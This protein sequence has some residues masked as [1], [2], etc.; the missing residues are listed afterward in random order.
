MPGSVNSYLGRMAAW[1]TMGTLAPEAPRSPQA[2]PGRRLPFPSTRVPGTLLRPSEALPDDPGEVDVRSRRTRLVPPTGRQGGAGRLATRP[3]RVCG[4]FGRRVGLRRS[5]TWSTIVSRMSG[6]R[7]P[8]PT[9]CAGSRDNGG[10]ISGNDAPRGTGGRTRCPDTGAGHHVRPVAVGRPRVAADR[11]PRYGDVCVGAAPAE[12]RHRGPSPTGRT[13]SSNLRTRTATAPLRLSTGCTAIS[14]S[15]GLG[16]RRGG[17]D[18]PRRRVLADRA[19]NG[20]SGRETM[21]V[22]RKIHEAVAG[23]RAHLREGPLVSNTSGRS[24]PA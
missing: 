5:T 23:F 6:Q 21:V 10:S 22:I 20:D 7:S 24:R 11:V 1:P 17:H 12:G 14:E 16:V 4:A 15:S 18:A 13:G 3:S 19:D 2:G 9:A 8:A